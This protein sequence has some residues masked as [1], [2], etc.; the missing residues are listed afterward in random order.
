MTEYAHFDNAIPCGG[1]GLAVGANGSEVSIADSSGNLAQAGTTIT[2]TA[3]ELNR[4][5]DKSSKV[6]TI[7]SDT[8][9]TMAAHDGKDVVMA[10]ASGGV[11][12]TLPAATGSGFDCTLI[13]G[14]ALASGDYI[15][16]VANATDVMNGSKAYGVDDDGEGASGFQWMAETG[17][18]TITL[19]GS[20]TGGLVGDSIRVRDYKAGFWL[21]EAKIIQNGTSA[22]PFTATVS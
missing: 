17:D 4:V 19:N 14:V 18:D 9:L 22:T 10:L 2:A 6:V 15:V 21:C 5:C 16:K 7:T 1:S 12:A 3:A 13:A 8:S 11:T 20:T